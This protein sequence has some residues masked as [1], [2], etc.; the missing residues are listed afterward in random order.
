MVKSPSWGGPVESPQDLRVRR[1]SARQVSQL[2]LESLFGGVSECGIV[3]GDAPQSHDFVSHSVE[4][5]LHHGLE[6]MGA[7]GRGLE[8]LHEATIHGFQVMERRVVDGDLDLGSGKA[9]LASPRAE[10]TGSKR[11]ARSVLPADPLGEALAAC[12]EIQLLVDGLKQGIEAGRE[13]LEPLAGHEA[14]AQRT[15]DGLGF[16][17]HGHQRFS[18]GW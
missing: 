4:P 2:V 18:W 9:P 5:A 14:A 10:V 16:V 15:H 11:L 7:V 13:V 3:L 6:G 8:A 12:H 17:H 1:I